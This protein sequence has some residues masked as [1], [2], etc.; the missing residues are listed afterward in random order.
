MRERPPGQ[1]VHEATDAAGATRHS[2]RLADP[3][4]RRAQQAEA[5]RRLLVKRAVTLCVVLAVVAAALAA[6]QL[7][8]RRLQAAQA[9]RIYPRV[10]ALGQ[11]LGGLTA[12]E[13]LATLQAPGALAEPGTVTL[14]DGERRWAFAGRELGVHYDVD[15]VVQAAMTVGRRGSW[16]ARLAAWLR[17]EEVAPLWAVD[18]PAGRAALAA[19]P[20]LVDQPAQEAALSLREEQLVAVPGVPGRALDVDATLEAVG[21]AVRNRGAGSVEVALSFQQLSPRV[22]DARA[23]LPQAEAMLQRPLTLG[24]YDAARSETLSWPLER[25]TVVSWLRVVRPGDGPGLAVQVSPQAVRATL[26]RLAAGLDGGRGFRLEEATAQVLNALAAGGGSVT[27]YLTHPPRT[28]VVERGEVLER[29]AARYGMP[30]SLIVAANPGLQPD[31]LDV[32]QTLTI[33]SL[34]ALLPHL[35]V[36]TK[37]IVVSLGEQRLRAYEQGELRWDWPCSTGLP[38]SPTLAGTFQVL[39]KAENAHASRWGVW[40]PHLLALYP[41][42]SGD[43]LGIHGPPA[44]ALGVSLWAGRLGQPGSLG[45]IVLGAGEAKTLYEW[46]EV[47]V[48]VAVEGP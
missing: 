15:G 9:G 14:R 46:A 5:L 4:C 47:G 20:A 45:S 18:V 24:A 31:R 21:A 39:D 11:C 7:T 12:A 34:D 22:A 29:I 16:A 23:A 13:A 3:I 37:R 40:V 25:A 6:A 27:L 30:L 38:T 28:H 41:A 8:L 2:V 1:L 19:L 32:G 10:W 33:P 17:R 43:Y 35:P 36:P 26:A 44:N 48:P 42:G